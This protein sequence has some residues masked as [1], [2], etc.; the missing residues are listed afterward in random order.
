MWV[1]FCVNNVVMAF[2][3]LMFYETAQVVGKLRHKRLANLIGCC[4][5]GDERLLVAVKVMRGCLLLRTCLV[6]LLQSFYSIACNLFLCSW[7]I[8]CFVAQWICEILGSL[9]GLVKY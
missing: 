7:F 8:S 6:I 1:L 5:E 9:D 3:C 2:L 4:C